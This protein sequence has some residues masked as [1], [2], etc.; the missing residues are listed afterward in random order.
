MV[1]SYFKSSSLSPTLPPSLAQA[2]A[3]TLA[4]TPPTHTQAYPVFKQNSAK[5][6]ADIECLLVFYFSVTNHHKFSDLK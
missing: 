6:Y 4:H 2:S 3:C 1:G 5:L